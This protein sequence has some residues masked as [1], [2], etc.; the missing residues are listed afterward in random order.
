M[1]T[2]P[3]LPRV[4][5]PALSADLRLPD[6]SPSVVPDTGVADIINELQQRELL[7]PALLLSTGYCGLP[8]M[9]QQVLLLVAPLIALLGFVPARPKESV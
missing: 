4:P 9:L 6:S 5:S 1:S 7:A 3:S 2:A 8:W